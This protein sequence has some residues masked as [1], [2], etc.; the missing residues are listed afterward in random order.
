MAASRNDVRL[1]LLKR[2]RLDLGRKD[3]PM[4]KTRRKS[5]VAAD[6]SGN[7][8]TNGELADVPHASEHRWQQAGMKTDLRC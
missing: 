6:R 4:I 8:R 3:A 1:A 5:D 2:E 7:I